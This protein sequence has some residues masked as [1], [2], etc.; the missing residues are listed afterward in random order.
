MKVHVTDEGL[1]IDGRRKSDETYIYTERTANFP[2]LAEVQLEGVPV[3]TI[4]DAELMMT[5]ETINT[6][7][8]I[9]AGTLTSTTAVT[10]CGPERSR[11]IQKQWGRA[12]LFI[13]DLVRY[14]GAC[15]ISAK[16]HNRR[17]ALERIFARN[18]KVLAAH[19]VYLLEQ[20]LDKEAHYQEIQKKGGEGTMLKD[21]D[22][23]Y[24]EGKRARVIYKWKK[25]YPIDAFITGYVRAKEDRG[26]ANLVGAFEVSVQDETGKIR[27]IGACQVGTL[28]FR[29]EI[30]NPDGSLKEEFYGRV[31]EVRGNE[32][33]KGLRLQHCVLV[34]WRPDKGKDECILDMRK[35]KAKW[36][37]PSH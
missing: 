10:T 6:G 30:S 23:T 20:R 11:E 22:G 19:D 35:I 4:F 7:S 9:T 26:W 24:R 25:F 1:R 17:K 8:V 13:F 28:E 29:K 16:F 14:G 36:T 31:V 2:H 18:A 32:W 33:T 27:A 12:K 21:L 34:G 5:S 37:R 15:L 3:G